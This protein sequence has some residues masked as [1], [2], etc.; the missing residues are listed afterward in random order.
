VARLKVVNGVRVGVASAAIVPQAVGP[1]VTAPEAIAARAVT[2][3][4][5]AGHSRW[6]RRLNSKN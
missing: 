4:V 1:M 5:A 6:L 3:P 2:D